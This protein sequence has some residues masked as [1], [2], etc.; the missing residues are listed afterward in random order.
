MI[1]KSFQWCLKFSLATIHCPTAD[2]LPFPEEQLDSDSP[3][4][5]QEF[6]HEN[7]EN[8]QLEHDFRLVVPREAV[9]FTRVTTQVWWI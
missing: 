3:G 7:A 5:N 1:H 8:V 4:E 6:R 2:A 9:K